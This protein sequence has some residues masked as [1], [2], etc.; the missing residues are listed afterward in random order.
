M[1]VEAF[2]LGV[3]VDILREELV[4]LLPLAML[5]EGHDR[6]GLL[7]L[8]DAPP[9]ASQVVLL[10]QPRID[11]AEGHHVPLVLWAENDVILQGRNCYVPQVELFGHELQELWGKTDLRRERSNRFKHGP[12]KGSRWLKDLLESL[13]VLDCVQEHLVDALC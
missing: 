3:E 6:P 4:D 1:S 9:Q 8:S 13:T 7:A 10:M 12:S 5:S 2:L 11:L